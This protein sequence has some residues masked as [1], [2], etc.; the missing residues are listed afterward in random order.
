MTEIVI[1]TRRKPC[2]LSPETS[3]FWHIAP[4]IA[5]ND[6]N[7]LSDIVKSPRGVL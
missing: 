6:K 4:K 3:A 1:K 2:F 5:T 7:L